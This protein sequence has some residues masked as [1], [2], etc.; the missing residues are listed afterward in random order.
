MAPLWQSRLY[1]FFPVVVACFVFFDFFVFSVGGRTR[2][3]FR[4]NHSPG[5]RLGRG[6]RGLRDKGG[7]VR[8][9]S[10]RF[11]VGRFGFRGPGSGFRVLG[12]GFGVW[13]LGFGA[14]LFGQSLNSVEG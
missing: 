11:A 10:D 7:G 8:L 4:F 5:L 3:R 2:L 1:F 14:R 9:R 6:D 12:L 13:G